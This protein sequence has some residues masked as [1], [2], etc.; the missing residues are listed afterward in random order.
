MKRVIAISGASGLIGAALS[1]YLI[2]QGHE[3]RHLVRSA[4]RVAAP[5]IAW[6]V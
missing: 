6:S 5:H 1:E 3:V 2:Q 4:E